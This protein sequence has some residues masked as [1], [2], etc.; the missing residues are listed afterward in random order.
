MKESNEPVSFQ[1]DSLQR[2]IFD[3]AAIRSEWVHIQETW[4][5]VT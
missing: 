2:F 3:N 4:Q 5:E 1:S